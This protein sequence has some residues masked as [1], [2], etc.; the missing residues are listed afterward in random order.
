MAP[1]PLVQKRY[2]PRT[3]VRAVRS[4]FSGESL[5]S[6]SHRSTEMN[7]YLIRRSGKSG[8]G[9]VVAVYLDRD[10]AYTEVQKLNQAAAD[11]QWSDSCSYW[12]ETYAAIEGKYEDI[13]HAYH[14]R[15]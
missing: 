4:I 3:C 10:H 5:L 9:D 11:N 2:S 15:S 14:W 7:V 12:V 1:A 8:C 13:S 6:S